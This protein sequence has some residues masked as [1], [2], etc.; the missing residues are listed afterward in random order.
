[1]NNIKLILTNW[2]ELDLGGVGPI[3]LNFNLNDIRD[4]SSRG[5][6][7]SK[8][9]KLY[10]TAHN[11]AIL[12]PLFDVNTQFLSVNP[13]RIEPCVLSIDGDVVLEGIFQIRRIFKA[14]SSEDE[15]VVY[16]VILKSNN[17]DFYT[18]IDG[19]FLTDL[20]LSRYNHVHDKATIMDSIR[21]GTELNG[22]QYY[23]AYVPI[24]EWP[25]GSGNQYHLYEP[26]DFRPAIYIKSVMDQIFLDAGFTYTFEELY[27]LN[28][29]KLIMTTNRETIVP[30]L[31]GSLFR[32][33]ITQFGFY[34][35]SF[36]EYPNN[37]YPSPFAG[38]PSGI[39][40]QPQLNTSGIGSVDI[41]DYYWAP[42]DP[43]LYQ[44]PI[45]FDDDNNTELNLFDVGG[46]YNNIIGEYTLD[47]NENAMYFETTFTINTWI[48][49]E[50]DLSPYG[51]PALTVIDTENYGTI[52][53]D[54][55]IQTTFGDGFSWT[56]Q[57]PDSNLNVL[58][59][60]GTT[61]K[62]RLTAVIIAYDVND[63]PLFPPIG[64]QDIGTNEYNFDSD[65]G[66]TWRYINQLEYTNQFTVNVSGEFNRFTQPTA[67][68][69]KVVVVSNFDDLSP[70]LYWGFKWSGIG[71][72]NNPTP[73]YVDISN[74][75]KLNTRFGFETL[76]INPIGYFKNDTSAYLG[77][78]TY[79]DMSKV[80]STDIKQSDFLISL[81]NMYNL[82]IIDDKINDKNLIIKTR[83]KFYLDGEDMNWNDKVDIKTIEI[84]IL[85]NSQTKIKDF[86]YTED[87]N[88]NILEAYRKNATLDYGALRYTF[89]NQFIKGSSTVKPI[90]SPA[91][92]Q[93]IYK[94]NIPFIPSRDKT[95]SKILSVGQLYTNDTYF[96]YR[97][98]N[99]TLGSVLLTEDQFAYR[100]V[101]H[102]Y[103]NSFQPTEDINFGVCEFYSHNFNT[104]TNNNLFNRFY[105]TQ[106]DILENGYMMRAK[107]KL[108]YLDISKL[109]MNE[110]IFI[111]NHWWN[112]N[113]IIDFDLNS[114]SLTEV[115]LISAD[116]TNGEFVPNNNLL[117]TKRPMADVVNS[118]SQ[119]TEKSNKMANTSHTEVYGKSNKIDDNT[120]SVVIGDFNY[121]KN[122]NGLVIGS[123][124]LIDG[125]GII[126]LGV[127]NKTLI[128]NNKVYVNGLVEMVD[129]IDGGTNVVR[130]PFGD[131]NI[132][133]IDG[134]TDEVLGIGSSTNI[135][136]INANFGT[137]VGAILNVYMQNGY[138]EPDYVI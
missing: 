99:P 49:H 111:N 78:G 91:A 100:H 95:D 79:I 48:K 105:R 9:I 73:T 138:V 35:T 25:V 29:D 104:I 90:F 89:F 134:S 45:N 20:N 30:G 103:P 15:I 86:A 66:M 23:N 109:K 56:F 47:A 1:M 24:V 120:N 137:S 27:D 130:S 74:Q 65:P 135:H 51:L 87:T 113:R 77:E 40:L 60:N 33:G 34:Q 22:Y 92:L 31:R 26:D 41:T 12:G 116:A 129:L 11:N 117:I 94:K 64:I 28:F 58:N 112:I 69:V 119:S 131:T 101:G 128:G 72:W 75:V 80:I 18:I 124:N 59:N 19:K 93:F 108:N 43:I 121:V 76:V 106:Y 63:Q 16:D 2:G 53:L 4:I 62:E 70:Q 10:G 102:F 84:D 83:D 61:I 7:F 44:E 67:T 118:W 68:K 57:S 107:F 32:A 21:N 50:K 8:T 55:D 122:K 97:I 46:Q 42:V 136:L 98:T 13:Q 126:A 88:D 6:V 85:S 5:G 71:E 81:I 82:Y 54:T 37:S 36:W 39:I 38:A 110:R 127:N 123:S 17:S 96:T 52:R 133:L 132:H 3:P 115:E 125:S 14:Y 114:N